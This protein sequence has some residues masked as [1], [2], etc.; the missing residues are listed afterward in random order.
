MSPVD[1]FWSRCE[2]PIE[3]GRNDCCITTADVI[4]AAGGPD[5]MSH[6]RGRYKTKIGYARLLAKGRFKTVPEAVTATLFE[7]CEPIDEPENFNVAVVTYLDHGRAVSA[8]A[9]FFDG[10]WLIRTDRGGM[11]TRAE[12]VEMFKVI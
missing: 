11:C 7:R 9:F 8:P 1:V 5:L 3:F 2:G 12:P 6:Y 10:F 4:L